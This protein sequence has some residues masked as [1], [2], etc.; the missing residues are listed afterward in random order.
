MKLQLYVLRQLVIALAFAVGGISFLVFPAV[1]VN[2]VHKLRGAP[3]QEILRFIPMVGVELVP[4]LLPMGFLLAV[5]AVFGRLAADNEWTAIRMAGIHPGKMLVPCAVLAIPLALLT[6][7][8]I[9]ELAPDWKFNQRAFKK[10]VLQRV[11]QD[12]SPGL[13]T[14]SVGDFYLQAADRTDNTFHKVLLYIPRAA[15]EDEQDEESAQAEAPVEFRSDLKIAAES[16]T[17]IARDDHLVV[18]FVDARVIKG[19][20]DFHNE[21]PTIVIPYD[22]VTEDDPMKRTAA[23]YISTSKLSSGLA[24]RR[25]RRI[26]EREIEYEV[27]RRH[28]LSVTYFLFLLIGFPTGLWLRKG[29]QLAAF[30]AATGYG[31]LYYVLAMRVGK[32]LSSVGAVPPVLGAWTVNAVGLVVG[33]LLSRK[34]LRR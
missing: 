21:N 18:R 29:S 12:L 23:K 34:A 1:A 11:I 7:W 15:A 22:E 3:V 32:E 16:A 4:F 10:E 5:T 17:I 14:I 25:V 19:N 33:A 24:D 9:H 28:A 30:A 20:E 8:I 27:H 13:T 31:F 2:A 6:G 26:G